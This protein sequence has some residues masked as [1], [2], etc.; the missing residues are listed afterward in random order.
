M[1]SVTSGTSTRAHRPSVLATPPSRALLRLIAVAV[2]AAFLLPLALGL[3]MPATAVTAPPASLRPA[4][5]PTPQYNV[6]FVEKG[7]PSGTN[8]TAVLAGTH[9]HSVTTQIVVPQG[10]GTY[11]WSI[12]ALTGWAPNN[13]SGT[14]KVVGAPITLYVT[15]LHAWNVSISEN[16]LP[17]S[18][19]WTIQLNGTNRT[20]S[21]PTLGYILSNAT[22]VFH[23]RT[24]LPGPT[25]V[26]YVAGV[27]NYTITVKGNSINRTDTF[28]TQFLLSTSASPANGGT[29]SPASAW[30]VNQTHVTLGVTTNTGFNF[31]GWTGTGPGS[32]TG[33]LTA[34]S[35][36]VGAPISEVAD[37]TQVYSVTFTETGLPTG[38]TWT[39]TLGGAPQS[40]PT[41]TIVFTEANG[42]YAYTVTGIAGYVA[43]PSSGTLTVAGAIVSQTISWTVKTY[44]VTFSETGLATGTSWTVKLNGVPNSSTT[45]LIG[46]LEPNGTYSYSITPIAGYTASMYGGAVTVNGGSQQVNVTWTPVTY[47]VTFV[48]TGLAAGT[49]WSVTLNGTLKSSTTSTLVFPVGNGTFAYNVSPLAGYRVSPTSGSVSVNG[50]DQTLSVLWMRL[51]TVSLVESGLPTGTSWS[52]TVAGT[53]LSGTTGVL[54]TLLVNGNYS[55][56]VTGIAGYRANAYQ[57]PF[58]VAGANVSIS[59]AWVV[60]TYTLT[61]SETGLAS[62]T[63][64]SVAAGGSVHSSNT[65]TIVF[66]EANGSVSFL[67]SAPSGYS[68]APQ[69][70]NLS[71]AG[72]AFTEA[73]AFTS[74]SSG[75]TLAGLTPIEFYALIGVLVF[76]AAA[77]V[78]ALT[79]R[80][81]RTKPKPK[82][83]E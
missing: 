22:Y 27:G 55:A 15:F 16:G 7:L 79:M 24:P 10:N 60:A 4:A 32:Y 12:L 29:A 5:G 62:G 30:Y 23:V 43:T 13:G 58:Q 28:T 75:T 11:T 47:S 83:Q 14:I 25:G 46:F 40:T 36:T 3:A 61:F 9:H 31:I 42:S 41:T 59:V 57:I 39:V 6:T 38:T 17:A 68:V 67:V 8:W 82:E 77:A 45:P 69:S 19:N 20:T 18:T 56:N 81:R 80:R 76:L 51:Y 78:L 49:S 1:N 70:G 71:I 52:V 35:I 72:A 44:A 65:S 63:T 2:M 73:I 74:T 66:N 50:A 54:S 21:V 37:F 34:P 53:L 26:R 33:P 64:W 48:E